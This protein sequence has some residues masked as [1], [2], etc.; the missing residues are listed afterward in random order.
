[1]IELFEHT[2]MQYALLGGLLISIAA[3][4]IGTLV[5][6]QRRVFIAGGI[7]HS[8]YGGVGIAYFLGASPI[9]GA[10]FFSLGAGLFMGFIERRS[11]QRVDTIIGVMWALGMAIGIL[12]IDLTK[13]YVVDLMS[14]LFGSIVAISPFDIALIVFVD[15]F[16]VFLVA[17]LYKDILAYSFDPE[18]SELMDRKSKVLLYIMMV[19]MSLA[20]VVMIRLVGVILVIALLT[21]PASI[22]E[23]FVQKLKPLMIVSI[24]L[25][26]LFITVGLVLSYY[27]NVTA[28]AL[29]V[30]IAGA[31]YLFSLLLRQVIKTRSA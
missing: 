2:F 26:V 3:G 18:F 21:I 5:V 6:I 8:A 12:F 9:L 31:F 10:L 4:I 24:L 17:V 11:R 25:S 22:A 19:L 27:L 15:L 20:V 1:M 13:G 16:V 29:I 23:Q 28:G 30:L 14:F 7:A